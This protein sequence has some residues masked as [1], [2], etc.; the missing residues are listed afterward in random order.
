MGLASVGAEDIAYDIT[1]FGG[2]TI[3]PTSKV[4]F[5]TS[6]E[7]LLRGTS[8]DP[9][10][11]MAFADAPAHVQ[12]RAIE[13][14]YTDTVAR[15]TTGAKFSMGE[16]ETIPMELFPFAGIDEKQMR[17]NPITGALMMMPPGLVSEGSVPNFTQII[18]S[19]EA[20]IGKYTPGRIKE[21]DRSSQGIPT[22][23]NTREKIIDVP[24]FRKPFVAPPEYTIPSFAF[25][26]NANQALSNIGYDKDSNIYNFNLAAEGRIPKVTPNFQTAGHAQIDT[27]PLQLSLNSVA[28][29]FDNLNLAANN[30]VGALGNVEAGGGEGESASKSA[31]EDLTRT[32]VKQMGEEL[33]AS[34]ADSLATLGK[35]GGEATGGREMTGN[36][37]VDARLTPTKTL[38]VEV[39]NLSDLEGQI[40]ELVSR[41][42]LNQVPGIA[43]NEIQRRGGL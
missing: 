8:I 33:K 10:T 37:T 18:S 23:F 21:L 16:G 38:S 4:A 7:E 35:H 15:F 14:A 1:T 2:K 25:K 32:L 31:L 26:R 41:E 40:K 43:R 9:R 22:F 11:R 19:L 13:I 17:R 28:L 24:G 6:T 30:L 27:E 42:L 12:K 34:L 20:N 3:L 29:G 36:L 5:K 39:S